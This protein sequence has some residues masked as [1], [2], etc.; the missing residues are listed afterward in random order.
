MSKSKKRNILT[1]TDRVQVGVWMSTRRDQ[2]K[3][4][5]TWVKVGELIKK[6]LGVTATTDNIRSIAD[7]FKPP[8]TISEEN[9]GYRFGSVSRLEFNQQAEQI[10]HNAEQINQVNQNIAEVKDDIAEIKAMLDRWFAEVK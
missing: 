4:L 3:S 1:P 6:D 5:T 9:N 7:T 10:N 2:I 8:I